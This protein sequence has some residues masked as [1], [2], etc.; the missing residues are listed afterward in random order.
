M[1]K[2]IYEKYF[3]TENLDVKV[4]S[5]HDSIID[6]NR[7]YDFFVDWSKIQQNVEKYKVEFNILN[8]LIGSKNF[9]KDVRSLLE[10]YPEIVSAIP[11]LL[12]IRDSR[13]KIIGD[14]LDRDSN[15]IE[16]DFTNRRLSNDEIDD[17]IYFLEKT[18]LQYFFE[19]L[20]NKSVIDYV[21]GVEVGMDTHAR[22]NRSGN[23]MELVLKP[24]IEEISNNQKQ[25]FIV[26][27]QKKFGFLEKAYK[28]PVKK[29]I[30]NRKAD[31]IILK[32]GRVINIE[33][34]FF[35]GTG[36][37]PQEIVDSYINRQ[38]ELNENRFNF[39]W[40]T[41][42]DGWRGQKNQI[43]KGFEKIEY[44]LNLHFVRMGLLEE[45]LCRI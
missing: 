41:D 33:V 34:N 15:I 37:K 6:T 9:R 8:S 27:F 40:I 24:I 22:K 16:Y 2:L 36:S 43:R 29:D 4:N 21:T 32:Q 31:F 10:K 35:S 7:G 13:L 25:P 11:I 30:K 42:G 14:F 45:I 38:N 26:L 39:I 18:G 12:A 1:E 17:L 20:T 5:F 19:H 3:N 23:S 44:L 28:I